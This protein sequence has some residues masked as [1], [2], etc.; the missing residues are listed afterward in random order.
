MEILVRN[1][2]LRIQ[3]NVWNHEYNEK[4]CKITPIYFNLQ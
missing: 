1:S 3:L 4:L 2:N